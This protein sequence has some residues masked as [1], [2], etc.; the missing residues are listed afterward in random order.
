MLQHIAI[1]ID[2]LDVH[3][4]SFGATE[5]SDIKSSLLPNC[6][7]MSVRSLCLH[8]YTEN[9]PIHATVLIIIL[10]IENFGGYNV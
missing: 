4:P 1:S 8:L 5:S 7:S 3:I 9:F 2:E 6:K 10:L